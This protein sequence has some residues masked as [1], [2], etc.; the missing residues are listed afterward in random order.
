M[1]VAIGAREP[2]EASRR[3]AARQRLLDLARDEGGERAVGDL[4]R[5]AERP[6]AAAHEALQRP[7]A[8]VGAVDGAQR[9]GRDHKAARGRGGGQRHAAAPKLTFGRSPFQKKA[10]SRKTV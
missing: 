2:G 10:I 3:V 1:V 6:P 7:T 5:R 9:A 8:P 4:E